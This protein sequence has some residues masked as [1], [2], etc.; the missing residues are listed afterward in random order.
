[1][2]GACVG[3]KEV[4]GCKMNH[5]QVS[6]G[7]LNFVFSLWSFSLLLFLLR[8][9]LTLLLRQTWNSICGKSWPQTR[10]NTLVTAA[11]I[12]VFRTVSHHS[13]LPQ[14]FWILASSVRWLLLLV[15]ELHINGSMQYKFFYDPTLS[16][17]R[18]YVPSIHASVCSLASS[19]HCP[20]CT[21][22]KRASWSSE[23]FLCRLSD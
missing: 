14:V 20:P 13:Q 18:I 16:P 17:N 8:Q 11:Q 19:F 15:L 3:R 4:A 1:M 10:F 9:S 22:K 6:G 2:H 5:F 12:P 7:S 21:P 23:G